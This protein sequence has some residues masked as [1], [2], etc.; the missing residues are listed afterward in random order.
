M[1][2]EY[3]LKDVKEAFLL[4]YNILIDCIAYNNISGDVPEQYTSVRGLYL[5]LKN[6][7][8]YQISNFEKDLASI[9]GF[10]SD[11]NADIEDFNFLAQGYKVLN[12]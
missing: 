7:K 4:K 2:S 5:F 11:A 8:N 9:V 1:H 6:N 10:Y 12:L 3:F